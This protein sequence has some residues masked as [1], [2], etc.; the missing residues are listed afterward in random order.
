MSL[1]VVH[2]VDSPSDE[3]IKRDLKVYFSIL[4]VVCLV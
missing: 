4:P 2:L 1:L 3:Y